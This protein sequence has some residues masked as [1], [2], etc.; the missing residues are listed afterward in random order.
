[1]SR[2]LYQL[3]YA[4]VIKLSIAYIAL[5]CQY[6]FRRFIPAYVKFSKTARFARFARFARIRARTARFLQFEK[7]LPAAYRFDKWG[8]T[9]TAYP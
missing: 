4:A 3:S 2:M 6:G 1:M 7:R 9:R 8:R 5:F